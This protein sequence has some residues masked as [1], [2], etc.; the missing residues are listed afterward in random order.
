[1]CMYVASPPPHTHTPTP[2]LYFQGI[3]AWEWVTAQHF[4][5]GI[6]GP[7]WIGLIRGINAKKEEVVAASALRWRKSFD[8]GLDPLL[9]GTRRR[10]TFC[11]WLRCH[12][13]KAVAF[14]SFFT[15]WLLLALPSWIKPSKPA[16]FLA[17]GWP[18]AERGTAALSYRA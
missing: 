3:F 5:V 18:R 2:V 16:R 11:L 4:C 13:G 10:G 8:R 1:M 17:Y 15:F 14:C 9:A 7:K 12:T 6:P